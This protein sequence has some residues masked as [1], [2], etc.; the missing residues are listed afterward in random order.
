MAPTSNAART[1][2]RPRAGRYAGNR[3]KF[4]QWPARRPVVTL[5]TLEAARGQRQFR[6]RVGAASRARRRCT[7][8]SGGAGKA[9]AD[10][11]S[12]RRGGQWRAGRRA[13][14]RQRDG[15]ESAVQ[16]D[17][18]TA[19]QQQQQ[20][21]RQRALSSSAQGQLC[22]ERQPLRH[23]LHGHWSTNHCRSWHRPASASASCTLSHA[24]RL[25]DVQRSNI[26]ARSCSTR[27]DTRRCAVFFVA[28]LSLAPFAEVRLIYT[29]R[30]AD[31]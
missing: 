11:G 14:D 23:R 27:L 10:C 1:R 20:L 17:V 22:Q 31:A 30:Y 3:G 8:S 21:S 4:G 19:Q 15:R 25:V 6:R 5:D 29:I 13:I 7:E 16:T 9:V 12:R 24:S 2:W 18:N 28:R 26:S